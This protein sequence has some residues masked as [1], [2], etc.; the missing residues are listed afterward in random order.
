MD[1]AA[2]N[3]WGGNWRIPTKDE[4]EELRT[5][6]TWVWTN[7]N[8]VNGYKITSNKIGYTDNSIFLPAA[9]RR[10]DT[11]LSM[12]GNLGQYWSKNLKT[13]FDYIENQAWDFEFHNNNDIQEYW[14]FRYIG[15]PIRPVW[16]PNM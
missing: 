5:N 3:Q 16:D 14:S 8:G 12:D 7:V 4:F 10:F 11:T 9:G 2:N 15:M 13:D 6:C 1:D